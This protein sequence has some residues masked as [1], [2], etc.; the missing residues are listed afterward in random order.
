MKP[1]TVI[2][3]VIT[4]IAAIVT[5][6]AFRKD[7]ESKYYLLVACTIMVFY[8]FLVALFHN[9]KKKHS[10]YCGHNHWGPV[11]NSFQ[12]CEICG[13]A[14]PAPEIVCRHHID[15]IISKIELPNK[16]QTSAEKALEIN[17]VSEVIYINRC[18]NCGRIEQVNIKIIE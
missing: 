18:E 12:Y 15:E 6:I 2:P 3:A 17:A 16:L 8:A 10:T 1:Q 7:F 9:K 11:H 13:T 4:I 14:K 5:I